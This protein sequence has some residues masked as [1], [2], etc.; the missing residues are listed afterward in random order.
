MK[1]ACR[2]LCICLLAAAVSAGSGE[3]ITT[4]QLLRQMIDLPRLASLPDP[5]YKTVQYSSFDR[6]SAL[7]GGPGWF[8][9]SDGFGGEETPNFQS[10]LKEP[11]EEG[12][13]EYVICDVRGPGAIVRTWTAA[14]AGTIRL[15]LDDVETP[16]YN[17]PAA[18]FLSCP[19][20]AFAQRLGIDDSILDGTFQQQQA[21]YCPIP[22]ARRCRMIWVGKIRQ[23]HFYHV[24]VRQ[25]EAGAAVST[26]R[27]E[28]LTTHMA[29]LQN[30]ARVLADPQEAYG[31][32]SAQD[33]L[34]IS[35]TIPPGQQQELLQ[36]SGPAALERLTLRLSAE[37]RGRALRQTILQIRCDAHAQAQVQ[38]PLGDFF[39]AA[40]GI[41]PFDAL[42]LTVLPDGTMT[43]RYLMPFKSSLKLV[44]D[45]RGD[46]AVTVA[47]SAVP[48]EH[49]WDDA[50]SLHFRARWRV[51]HDV[52]GSPHAVQDMPVLLA[53]GAGRY[54]G[55]AVMLLNPCRVP[56]PSGGW[57]GEGDEKIFVD[58]DVRPS[59]FG[60]G[61]EDYFN[62]AWS[63]PDIFAYAYCGQPRNDGPG[64]RGFIT[65]QRW[66]ILDDLPFGRRIAF[67]LELFPHDRT[68]GIS[69][70]RLAYHYARPGTF[71]DHVVIRDD[72]LRPPV[73]PGNWQPAAYSGMRGSVYHQAEDVSQPGG[74]VSLEPDALWAG[75]RLLLW[76]PAQEGAQLELRVPVEEQGKYALH[77]ALAHARYAGRISCRLDGAPVGFG[78]ARIIDLHV[79]HRVLSRQHRTD[80]VE[81]TAGEHVLTLRFEGAPDDVAEPA[82][83][84]D[85]V[86][87]QRR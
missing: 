77:L 85:Y 86:A 45:N 82:I 52:L 67:Y 15:L 19:Y 49:A 23:V 20:R 39:G 12:V 10:V 83:G 50:R 54:V 69:Y 28:D 2:L 6:R 35:A 26:F 17:G 46:Q 70:A 66:H 18:D 64:N 72:D 76:K 56:T 21:A 74:E 60:T 3:P 78:D 63:V 40:P 14:C 5:A 1:T 65:N 11:N 36:L 53:G 8:A 62:Y 37:D 16:L 27:P 75:G 71:D 7:P 24:Q 33:P 13:G 34:E 47:G 38:A 41:N 4:G 68:A 30:V 79:P 58:D 55:T 84:I 44:L 73:L 51:D 81:L 32:E 61:S 80:V 43:C 42:P 25:Y 9:N 57:W 22:F 87:I 48:V 31:L 29:E 59:T